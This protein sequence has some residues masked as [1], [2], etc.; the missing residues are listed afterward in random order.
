MALYRERFAEVLRECLD[1]QVQAEVAKAAGCDRA[2][3]NRM[4]RH[5]R[6]PSQRMLG[7]VA[8][9]LELRGPKRRRLFAAAGYVEVEEVAA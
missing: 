5:G 4:A 9:A 2:T 1:G 6:V 7:A 8:D 3:I